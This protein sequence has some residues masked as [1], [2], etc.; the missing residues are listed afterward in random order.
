MAEHR[1]VPVDGL[2]ANFGDL[3]GNGLENGA[4]AIAQLIGVGSA[5][6]Q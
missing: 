1:L 4:G 3:F 6:E 5:G 2:A